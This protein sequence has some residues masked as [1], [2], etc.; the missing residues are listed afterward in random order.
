MLDKRYEA[1]IA[2]LY[3]RYEADIAMLYKQYEADRAMLDKPILALIPDC[4]W[5]GRS[6]FSEPLQ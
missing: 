5:N 3:K 2:P 6:I 1:D 4:A